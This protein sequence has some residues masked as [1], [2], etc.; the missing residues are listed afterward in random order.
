MKVETIA[1]QYFD[2]TDAVYN[3]KTGDHLTNLYY[4]YTK[5]RAPIGTVFFMHGFGGSPAEEFLLAAQQIALDI[6][7][8]IAAV[9]GVALSATSGEPKDINKMRLDHQRGALMRGILRAKNNHGLCQ[10]YNIAWAHSISCRALSDLAMDSRFV[11]GFFDEFVLNNPYFI[12]TTKLMK[13]RARMMKRDPSGA[14]WR[15]LADKVYMTRQDIA[16]KVFEVPNAPKCFD[17]PIP[18]VELSDIPLKTAY[19]I[20]EKYNL[21]ERCRGKHISFILGMDDTMAEYSINRRLIGGLKI[22][23][24]TIAVLDNADHAFQPNLRGYENF[25]EIILNQIKSRAVK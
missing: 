18:D 13:A 12:T 2:E 9:E 23:H 6:G 19:D 21:G 7:F 11:S 3:I 24:K 8:D 17:L 10:N 25:S 16:G 20:S 5:N 14:L 1:S 22:P 4:S 15:N